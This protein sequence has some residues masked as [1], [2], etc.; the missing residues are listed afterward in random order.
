MFRAT[1]AHYFRNFDLGIDLHIFQNLDRIFVQVQ[2]ITSIQEKLTKV[3]GTCL[4]E[5]TLEANQTLPELQKF[6]H[7]GKMFKVFA[8]VGR[9]KLVSSKILN[10]LWQ[11]FYAIWQILI[12]VNDQVF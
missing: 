10:I 3:T 2:A 4:N 1:R 5:K 9:F 11:I 7:F 6:R 12:F 8:S